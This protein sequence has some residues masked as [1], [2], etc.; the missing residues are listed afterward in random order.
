MFLIKDSLLRANRNNQNNSPQHQCQP[1]CQCQISRRTV[2]KSILGSVIGLTAF[3]PIAQANN[4]Q[5]KALVFSCIDFR[6]LATERYFLSMKNLGNSYDWATLAGGSLALAGFPNSADTQA[7]WDQLEFSY[8]QHNIKRVLILDHQNCDAYAVKF[9]PDLLN[10][11]Q[12]ELQIHTEY[13]RQAY[14]SIN[15]RY[16]ELNVELYFVTLNNA[17]V[18]SISPA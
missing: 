17:E 13:L 9:S 14:W 10:N 2:L 18:L 6:F 8:K 7:F 16:P 1:H 12:Q 3:S 5:A 4:N 15:T 11:S